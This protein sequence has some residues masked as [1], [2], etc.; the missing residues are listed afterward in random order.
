MHRPKELLNHFA[1]VIDASYSMSDHAEAVVRVTDGEV[2][3]LAN[4]SRELG[5]DARISMYTFADDVRNEVFDRD[6]LRAPSVAGLYRVRGNTALIDATLKAITDLEQTAQLY[7]DH[8]FLIYVVTDGENNR[9]GHRARELRAKLQQLP[10]NWTVACLVPDGRGKN[11]AQAFG[12]EPENIV[13]WDATSRRGLE[14]AGRVIRQASENFMT[15]RA[16]GERGTR[17]LFSTGADAVN[18]ATVE[19]ALAPINPSTYEVF[20][21][22]RDSDIRDFLARNG[23][24]LRIGSGYYQFTKKVLIQHHKKIMVRNKQTGQVFGGDQ[25]RDLIGLDRNIDVKVEPDHNPEWSIFIQSTSPN[26]KLLK[27]TDLL[28]M[29]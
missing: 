25:A 13:I 21:V 22:D 14:D 27:G 26:R 15:G 2:E 18:S 5:Q 23:R 10:V 7:D 16:K 20:S 1:V 29:R 19:A 24:Q 12:F 17:S 4:R 9:N 8:A 6:V 28:L 11:N 3:H